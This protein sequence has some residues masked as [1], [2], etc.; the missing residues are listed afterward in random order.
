MTE[1]PEERS[2]RKFLNYYDQHD[3]KYQITI[4]LKSPDDVKNAQELFAKARKHFAR[5]N[6]DYPTL[7]RIGVKGVRPQEVFRDY[8][9]DK[10]I[11]NMPY[12]TFFTTR[13][14][15]YTE[16][17]ALFDNLKVSERFDIRQR[18]FTGLKPIKYRRSVKNQRPHNLKAPLGEKKI[19]RFGI[20]NPKK[21]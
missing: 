1:S 16:A 8:D 6:P 21:N 15:D 17:V 5:K 18:S 4:F 2:K 10:S 12:I 7:W 13:E 14:F 19:N 11:I 3:W 20:L 9:G